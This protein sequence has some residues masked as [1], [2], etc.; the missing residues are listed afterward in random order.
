MEASGEA[1][2]NYFHAICRLNGKDKAKADKYA[3]VGYLDAIEKGDLGRAI[4]FAET[5]GDNK[6]AGRLRMKLDIA[7]YEGYVNS[8]DYARAAELAKRMGF[9]RQASVCY[10]YAS[11][12]AEQAG[13][14]EAA[15]TYAHM[16]GNQQ[17][18]QRLNV[19]VSAERARKAEELRREEPAAPDCTPEGYNE[20][21]YPFRE[22]DAITESI[23]IRS[24]LIRVW[25][26]AGSY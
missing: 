14:I 4:L 5:A 21:P 1:Q 17:E 12:Q 22:K 11:A 7:T 25:G 20:V 16:S 8:G 15:Y 19:L 26:D 10:S 18:I 9:P 23:E 3:L 24:G 6:E 2:E 13:N